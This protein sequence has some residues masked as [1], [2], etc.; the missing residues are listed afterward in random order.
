MRPFLS[1]LSDP[2]FLTCYT[3]IGGEIIENRALLQKSNRVIMKVTKIN[4]NKFNRLKIKYLNIEI[5][6][7]K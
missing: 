1:V 5:T 3:S 6:E 4:R 2:D 7:V